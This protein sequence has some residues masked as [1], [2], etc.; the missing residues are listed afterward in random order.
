M[1]YFLIANSCSNKQK[2]II[3]SALWSI[4]IKYTDTTNTG[5][6]HSQSI[7]KI[8]K[9]INFKFYEVNLIDVI[10]VVYDNL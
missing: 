6:N 10:L 1:L 8:A 3:Q 4:V 2:A 9:Y 7:R 5:R